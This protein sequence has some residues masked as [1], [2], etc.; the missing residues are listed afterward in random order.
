MEHLAIDL[1]GTES[2]ICVRAADETILEERRFATRSLRTYFKKRPT[3]RVILETSSSAFCI[4]DTALELGHEVRVVPASLV[5]SLG[6]GDRGVKTD[7]K[8]ARVLS[9]VS[10]RI[11]LPSV[12]IPSEVSRQRKAMCGM[13]EVLVRARTAMINNV[14]GWLRGQ[15]SRVGKGTAATLPARVRQ[16]RPQLPRYVARMLETIEHLNGQI[17]EADTELKQQ[18]EQD[19]LCKRLMTVPG[20][21]PVTSVRFVAAID[22]IS[23]FA[24]A[25]QVES[26]LG[27]VPGEKQ[28]SARQH[29]TSITKAG[30]SAVRRAL[31]QAAW[32]ARQVRSRQPM[33]D[34]ML[35]IE[36]RRGK[37]IATVALARKLAGILF[38]L[39]RDGTTYKPSQ[40]ALSR[41]PAQ[42]LD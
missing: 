6:V 40:S 8:D 25:H 13:R 14:K 11:D 32:A 22:D 39:W 10:C 7:V 37:Q 31:V 17:K 24:N 2:Q 12:H 34:W 36:K 18:A 20:V 26:Y 19:P 28:S 29:R 33:L 16:L 38:A 42:A 35:E 41:P 4:A 23:R 27:L 5:R 3:S 1:G 30:A 21:G 9:E 15:N